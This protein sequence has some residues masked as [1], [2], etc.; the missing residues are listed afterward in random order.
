MTTKSV[1]LD[2]IAGTPVDKRVVEA[3]L[4]F[5]TENYGNPSAL[6]HLGRTAEDAIEKAGQQVAA[7]INSKP[8]EIIFTSCGTESNNFALK[9]LTQANVKKGKH[10]IVSAI[11]HFSVLHPL[12]TLEKLGFDFSLAPVD[13]DGI[14]QL[15]E[16]KKLIRP[17]TVLISVTH[18]S[19]EIGVVQ[20]IKEIVEIA[21]QNN[22][23]THTDAIQAVGV[24]PV[25]ILALGVDALSLAANQFYG[26][27]GVAALYLKKGTRIVTLME[28]GI[29]EGG[30]RAGT[31]N[32]A[33]I[34]AMGQAAELAKV[35]MEA[36]LVQ[37]KKIQAKLVAGLKEKV[38]TFHFTGHPEKRLTNHVSGVVEF[39]E[40]E[41]ISMFLDMEGIS[42]STG[43]ACVSK[44]LKASHV[45]KAIGVDP[46]LANGSVV[47]SFG[48]ETTEADIDYFLEKFPPI[49]KRLQ[50][51]SPLK[52]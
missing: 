6:Y 10:V 37:F 15:D 26:P 45:V 16:L 29:Q 31:E 30:K 24:I 14:V 52:K 41:S 33:G 23:L 18:A 27:K 32:V 28:G 21:K 3:M 42:V 19:N 47:L 51:M 8:E 40:G 48:K 50:D 4:P 38:P 7:L 43:S 46:A 13:K 22:I 39:I 20:P 17:D 34:V 12:K 9:G 44:I 25:D 35:E 49:V 36:R 1:Y 11:E 5:L 2:H